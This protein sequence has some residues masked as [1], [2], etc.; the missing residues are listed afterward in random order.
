MN[1]FFSLHKTCSAVN[2][3]EIFRC[4]AKSCRL[5][6]SNY[7][8]KYKAMSHLQA[9]KIHLSCTTASLSTCISNVNRYAVVSGIFRNK[10]GPLTFYAIKLRRIHVVFEM[11]L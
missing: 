10:N 8:Q 2:N 7:E 11:L 9:E 6:L 3:V 1:S 4:I 5:K